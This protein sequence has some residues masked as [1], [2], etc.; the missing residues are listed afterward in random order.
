MDSNIRTDCCNFATVWRI[1]TRTGLYLASL[2]P[3]GMVGEVATGSNRLR[4]LD[5]IAVSAVRFR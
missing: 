2:P 1:A 5:A 4:S 3:F